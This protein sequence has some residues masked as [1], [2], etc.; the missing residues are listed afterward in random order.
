MALEQV[1]EA[2]PIPDIAKLAAARAEDPLA[3]PVM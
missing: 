2:R 3:R 1:L